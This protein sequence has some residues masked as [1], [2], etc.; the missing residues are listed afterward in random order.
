M[1]GSLEDHFL[2]KRIPWLNKIFYSILNCEDLMYFSILNLKLKISGCCL[3]QS[4]IFYVRILHFRVCFLRPITLFH[5]VVQL[6]LLPFKSQGQTT[7]IDLRVE[8]LAANIQGWPTVQLSKMMQCA[9]VR[10]REFELSNLSTIIILF[11]TQT[12][13]KANLIVLKERTRT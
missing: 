4:L 5:L 6:S 1:H 13:Y 7:L 9:E 10:K 3:G 8:L 11:K 12:I 2:V